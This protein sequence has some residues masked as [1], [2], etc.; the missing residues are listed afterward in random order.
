MFM[1][2]VPPYLILYDQ[3]LLAI[4]LVML[5]SSPAWRWGVVLF[6]TTTVLVVN[7]AMPLGFSLTGLA[8]LATMYILAKND[9]QISENLSLTS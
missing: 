3:T 6:S 2:L 9:C 1:L 7:L 8:A 4:P 5:W